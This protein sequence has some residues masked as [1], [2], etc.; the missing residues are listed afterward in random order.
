[1]VMVDRVAEWT[2]RRRLLTIVALFI[3]TIAIGVGMMA[4]DQEAGLGQFETDSVEGEKL[5]FINENFGEEG[6]NATTA[7]QIIVRGDNV[8]D[9]ESLIATVELQRD[10]AED[11]TVSETLVNDAFT[12]VGSVVATTIIRQEMVAQAQQ[13]PP[14]YRE[15]A[16]HEAQTYQPTFEEQIEALE[17][18][19][20]SQ[21]EEVVRNLFV[22][23]ETRG[24]LAL[25]P[26]DFEPGTAES[27]ARVIVVQQQIDDDFVAEGDAPEVIVNSQLRM[28]ELVEQRFDDGA[29]VFGQGIIT[30]E[31]NRSL[32][33]SL[34]LVIPFALLFVIVTLMIAYR[35]IL[36]ILLGVL[37]IVFVLIWT[38]G[39]MGWAG[40]DF[41]QIFIAVPVL[42]IGLSIDYAI[43]VFMRQREHRQ[44]ADGTSSSGA[45]RLALIGLLVALTWVTATAVFGFLANLVSPIE[46]IRQFG[47]V[48]A[49]GIASALVIFGLLI[50]AMKVTLDNL[51]EG[52]GIDRR[53]RAFGTGGGRFSGI[54]ASGQRFAKRAPV[55]V[56]IIALI[57]TAGGA[58][59]AS[60]IDTSFEVEDF[61][62]DKPPE[63]TQHLPAMFKPGEYQTKEN[64]RLIDD[65]F[66]RQDLQAQVLVEGDIT[67]DD[68]LVRLQTT[69]DD[70]A[71]RDITVVLA[72]GR[73]DI[74]SPLTVM[75][76]V[77]A[78]HPEFNET[79]TAADTTGDGIPD[80][81]LETVY[82][83]LFEVAPEQAANVIYRTE[84]G[85]YQALR[86]IVSIRGGATTDEVQ[87]QM[88]G[89][90]ATIDGDGF[91]A[92]A[93][94]QLIVFS[95][96]EEEL[97]E[98]VFESLIVSLVAVFLFLMLAYRITEGSATLGIV[99]LTPIMLAVAWILGTMY[100][101][102]MPFNVVTGTITS[103]T[104]GLGVA[105]NI[106]M[107]ERFR[108]ELRRGREVWDA[109]YVSTTGTGGALLGSAATTAGGFGV[110]ALAIIPILQ[111]FGII[112]A[113]TII[114]AFLGSVLVLPTLLILWLRHLA[115]DRYQQANVES[116]DDESV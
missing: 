83:H 54:L 25:M 67:R 19:E 85:E 102:G 69:M 97:F 16:L 72:D 81:D 42:L 86:M 52:Y 32:D 88:R 6:E 100:L 80:T 57:F 44:E 66:L 10:L 110:L 26:T 106:H 28:A 109:M 90:A 87:H 35:D 91:E 27:D 104:I 30:N 45:M 17:T 22:A 5:Q 78:E 21:L 38:F 71:E 3:L 82:D 93:T 107:S 76:E 84:D 96:I 112:T 95:I 1:M 33:D 62:A 23:E 39:F 36:D 40:I 49:F 61:I 13:K 56:L 15:E 94:G 41:N 115:P 116:T 14:E 34:A 92:T 8:L 105:Y 113:I 37:G 29:F 48:S 75:R 77:A 98:T 2:T 43:H 65:R 74:V 50:P 20:Q 58:Y 103:L 7:V 79:F 99:T 46:P 47:L 101:L 63:W 18:V 24:L 60:E 64:L 108:L 59:G 12:D 11:P 55:L 70:A 114:Y 73:T 31:L 68:T 89:V 9:R 53:K 51:L 111:Q 4:I